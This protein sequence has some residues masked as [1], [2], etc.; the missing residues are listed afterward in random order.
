MKVLI[1]ISTFFVGTLI[2]TLIGYAIGIR[3]GAIL[4]Y[5]VEYYI[6][7]KLC[8]KWDEHKRIKE[9]APAE[10]STEQVQP[11]DGFSYNQEAKNQKEIVNEQSASSVEEAPTIKTISYCRRCG[12]KLVEGSDFCSNCGTKIKKK[13]E[14]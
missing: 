5:I 8:E 10:L 11:L 7:K 1:W 14:V 12:F 9:A 13:E 6:A 2:N 4:L 3:A